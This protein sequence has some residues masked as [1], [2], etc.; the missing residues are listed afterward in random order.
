MLARYHY[1]ATLLYGKYFQ[2]K[3]NQFMLSLCLQEVVG[4]VLLGGKALT[5]L[6]QSQLQAMSNTAVLGCNLQTVPN[7]T[8]HVPTSLQ[9]CQSPATT[10]ATTRV[11][12]VQKLPSAV[13]QGSTGSVS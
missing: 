11:V 1:S 13:V 3:Q 12:T 7:Q 9:T 4:K 10:T 8:P 5:S 6:N 2:R